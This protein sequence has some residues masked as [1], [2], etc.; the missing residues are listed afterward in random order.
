M[1]KTEPGEHTLEAKFAS[2]CSVIIVNYN[3][4]EVLLQCVSALV[5][6]APV[7]EVLLVDNAST[8]GSLEQVQARFPHLQIIR[9]PENLGFSAAANQ[10]LAAACGAYLLLLNPDCLLQEDSLQ[11]MMSALDEYPQAGM[12]G[13]R[14]M[15]PDGSEQRGCRR[16][17]PTLGSGMRK[18]AGG[19]GSSGID[20]HQQELP[21]HPVKVEAISG[22]FML[23]RREAL[24]EVGMLDE[25]YFMHCEDLDWC[26]RFLD[27]NWKILFVPGV[28]VVHYQGSCSKSTPV[29]VSWY[30]HQG[31]IR[32][33]RKYLAGGRVSPMSY[34]VVPGIYAR[35]VVLN[36]RTLLKKV[37]GKFAGE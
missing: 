28:E 11:Q 22:A 8:D 12:A 3:A 31:M 29:R 10:G 25:G 24:Q 35:F 18:A 9:N 36:L 37:L 13:C 1:E 15:N 14:I 6:N 7:A 30:L 19:K 34:I 2:C 32:Y 21:G 27:A 26:R 4:G 16:R 20:L 33:Y 23:L 5:K 17:L